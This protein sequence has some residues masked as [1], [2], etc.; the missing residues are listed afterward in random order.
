VLTPPPPKAASTLPPPPPPPAPVL[1]V[2]LGLTEVLIG[3][4]TEA[5]ER[6]AV[7]APSEVHLAHCVKAL[8]SG[9]VSRGTTSIPLPHCLTALLSW[10]V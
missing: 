7:L 1:E 2:S 10:E 6:A 5:L 9:E 3:C 8:F 4:H